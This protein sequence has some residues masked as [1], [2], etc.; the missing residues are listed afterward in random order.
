[1]LESVIASVGPLDAA[2]LERC[3][4]RLDNL[5]KPLGSLHHLE[6]LA[7]KLAGVTG[8]H[9]PALQQKQSLLV[10]AA[11]H[12]FDEGLVEGE[13][14]TAQRVADACRLNSPLRVFAAKNAAEVVLVNAGMRE[15]LVHERLRQAVFSFGTCDWRQGPAMEEETVLA[16]LG[17]GVSLAQAEADKGVR[18]LGLGS[19]ACGGM[20]SALILLALWGGIPVALRQQAA[21]SEKAAEILALVEE[22]LGLWDGETDVRA[23]LKRFGGL[24]TVVLCGAILGGAARGMLL[25]LDGVETAAAALAAAQMQPLIKDYLIAPHAAA[26]PGFQEMLFLL[27]LPSYLQLNLQ[28]SEGIGA[29]LGMSLLRASLH[30][31]NDMK[32]FGEAAVA[33]AQDGPGAERQSHAIRD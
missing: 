21:A 29:V 33:V 13:K 4:R 22:A 5:T 31:L 25:V 2:A 7:L 3:Q 16:A 11:D 9:R 30:M 26:E 15:K 18:I 28:Q 6:F 19:I 24:E 8:Q 27:G 1:M 23:V 20:I 10:V 14:T 12:G 32:T 17:L